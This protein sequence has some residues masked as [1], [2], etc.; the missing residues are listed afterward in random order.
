MQ[1][2]T[3]SNKE[4]NLLFSDPVAIERN[5]RRERRLASI[6]NKTSSSIDATNKPSIDIATPPSID[7][8]LRAEM[9][10]TLILTR[11]EIGDLHD[12]EGH[13][14]NA[15]GQRLDAQRAA[16]PEHRSIAELIRPSQFYANR[17]A[18][19]PPKVQGIDGQIKPAYYTHVS[20]HP[21][22]GLPHE[23]PMD[24][25]E[26]LEDFVSCIPE[27]E[28][29]KD[30]ILCK[31]F[32]YSLSKD[33]IAWLK[34]LPPGSLTTWD[35]VKTA[36]LTEF[37]GARS[38]EL[39]DKI[40][41][42]SQGSTEAFKSSWERFR[43]YQKECPHH[44]FTEVQLLEIFFRGI[45]SR[46]KLMLDGASEGNIK[47]KTPEE[48]KRL[49]ENMAS[50]NSVKNMNVHMIE[51]AEMDGDKIVEAEVGSVHEVSSVEQ[52]VENN[53]NQEYTWM[54]ESAMEKILK[55]QQKMSDYFNLKLDIIYKE[56][57]GKL[58]AINTHVRMLNTQ[59]SQTA[60]ALKKQ[61]ALIKE[62]A[63]ENKRYHVDAILDDNCGKVIKHEK[64]EEDAFLV[65]SSMSIG[66]AYWCRSTPSAEH[67]STPIEEHVGT[68]KIQSHSNFA[69]QHPHPPTRSCIKIDDVDRHHQEVVDR[70]T[71]SNV[72]RQ[73]HPDIDRHQPDGHES[74]VDKQA[75]KER[76][77]EKKVRSTKP[78]VPKHLRRKVNKVELDGFR[79]R[80]KR[81]PKN[82]SFEDAYYQYRLGNF[83][84]ES[85]E[86]AKDIELLFNEI[87]RKPKKTLKKEE[88]PGKFLIPCTIHD[89]CFPHALCDTGSAVS[90]M[91][92]DT[93]EQL[94]LKVEPS[95]DSFAFVDNS[96]ANSA[97]VI[98]N[99]KVEIGDCTVPVDIHVVE[100]KSGSKSPLLFGRA[101]MATVGAVCDLKKNRM[102]LTNVDETMFYDPQEM[103]KS[104]EFISCLE[105]PDDPTPTDYSSYATA[106]IASASIDTKPLESIDPKPPESI[107]IQ[108][109]ASIDVLQIS[110]HTEF[111]KPKSGG[112]RKKRKKKKKVDAMSLTPLLCNEGSVGYKVRCRGGLQSFTKV[113][114]LCDPKL[115]DKGEASA[116]AFINNI[117]KMRKRD[118]ETC[119]GT[120]YQSHLD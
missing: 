2:S 57:N 23:D 68:V 19:R 25:I 71:S 78:Y 12:P 94:G 65:E 22:H 113:R 81:V 48:A 42:F 115:K 6:D 67:R 97:G 16:I 96:K 30:Y 49:I 64:L 84:R 102:C 10:A 110:E 47:T 50:C 7:G 92:K 3:R 55:I 74:F 105:V 1:S 45:H 100:I 32:R 79:K 18:I 112:R 108:L 118:T 75:A 21:F 14:C 106:K 87:S 93:A 107:D 83:F 46:Y 41:T 4:K 60:E 29:T 27:H 5:I 91:G 117:N 76:I 109:S 61:E 116:R 101:F 31:L 104:V 28:G 17:Y 70:H 72:D 39:R 35:D 13:L 99:V 40:C 44:G 120:S 89:T 86:T 53:E 95:Q 8:N 38:E 33:A 51:S 111:E 20:K 80:V 52:A 9:A 54:M 98:K 88:D 69:T 63:E 15:A 85:K 73:H 36:F 24:H 34:L 26:T 66:S 58:E 119:F 77:P 90:I 114:V 37:V 11:D 59:N 82:M 103:K 56:L 43:R 62:N